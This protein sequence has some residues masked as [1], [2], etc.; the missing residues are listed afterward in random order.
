MQLD[1]STET[2]GIV[3]RRVSRF[4]RG[5]MRT[6]CEPRGPVTRNEATPSPAFDGKTPPT[7]TS[8]PFAAVKRRDY[9]FPTKA[10]C[11]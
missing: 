4:S 2:T 5:E 1:E 9:H 8:A 6:N 7:R 3:V 10:S 11:E